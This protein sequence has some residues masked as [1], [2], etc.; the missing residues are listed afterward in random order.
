MVALSNVLANQSD[1]DYKNII[2]IIKT[3][4]LQRYQHLYLPPQ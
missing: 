4:L 1:P 2:K 3:Y